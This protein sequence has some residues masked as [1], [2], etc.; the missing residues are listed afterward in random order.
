MGFGKGFL[1]GFGLA[2][3][4][5]GIAGFLTADMAYQ[6]IS[7]HTAEIESL[8]TFVNSPAFSSIYEFSIKLQSIAKSLMRYS[9]ILSKVGLDPNELYSKAYQLQ[10]NLNDIRN[11]AYTLHSEVSGHGPSSSIVATS[12]ITLLAGIAMLAAGSIAQAIEKRRHKN[13]SRR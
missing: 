9:W 12:T 1:A 7:R 3:V 6:I 10:Q 4:L 8:Y 11:L 2:L 5:M 13:L